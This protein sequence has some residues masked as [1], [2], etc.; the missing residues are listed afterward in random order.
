MRV[1]VTRSNLA[2]RIAKDTDGLLVDRDFAVTKGRLRCKMLVFKDIRSMAR[3]VERTMNWKVGNTAHALTMELGNTVEPESGPE[4]M[5]VDRRYFAMV[6]F[7]AKYL[8][9]EVISHEA[10]HV[11]FAYDRRVRRKDLWSD[12]DEN[13]DEA[14]CY[15][16]GIAANQINKILHNTG[17]YDIYEKVRQ[18]RLRLRLSARGK[19]GRKIDAHRKK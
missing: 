13:S 18:R 16:A 10:V 2:R 14:I 15:P 9:A 3:F 1:V 17:M 19:S 8:S 7:C 4:Y 12:M 6:C 5:E 11:A